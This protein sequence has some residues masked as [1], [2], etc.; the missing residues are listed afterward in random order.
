MTRVVSEALGWYGVAV[1]LLAY[2]LV[3]FSVL[4][5]DD[6]WYQALNFTGALGIV[7]DAWSQ[8]N[9]QPAVLNVIWALVALLGLISMLRSV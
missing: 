8:K 7:V 9:Y 5:P 1:I 6:V 2:V 3:S 4:V